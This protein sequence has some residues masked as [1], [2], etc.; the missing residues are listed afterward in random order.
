MTLMKNCSVKRRLLHS[1]PSETTVALSSSFIAVVF[2]FLSCTLP[3]CSVLSFKAGHVEAVPGSTVSRSTRP[4]PNG[5]ATAIPSSSHKNGNQF[6]PSGGGG[7]RSA[8][9]MKLT[10]PRREFGG[11]VY[12]DPNNPIA[13][14]LYAFSKSTESQ[15]IQHDDEHAPFIRFPSISSPFSNTIQSSESHL[16]Q[17]SYQR[18]PPQPSK[19]NANQHDD[20]TV[21]QGHHLQQKPLAQSVSDLLAQREEPSSIFGAPHEDDLFDSYY[22]TGI[23]DDDATLSSAD[24]DRYSSREDGDLFKKQTATPNTGTSVDASASPSLA[25]SPPPT[26]KSNAITNKIK[27]TSSNDSNSSHDNHNHSDEDNHVAVRPSST[28]A[29]RKPTLLPLPAN[30]LSLATFKQ[31]DNTL[32]KSSSNILSRIANFWR[33]RTMSSH[34]S[35]NGTIVAV[36]NRQISNSSSISSSNKTNSSTNQMNKLASDSSISADNHQHEDDDNE[37]TDNVF[38]KNLD[39]DLNR[40][41]NTRRSSSENDN[42]SYNSKDNHGKNIRRQSESSTS[43]PLTKYISM[44]DLDGGVSNGGGGGILVNSNQYLSLDDGDDGVNLGVGDEDFATST[45][46]GNTKEEGPT[47]TKSSSKNNNELEDNFHRHHDHHSVSVEDYITS[48]ETSAGL[49]WLNGGEDSAQSSHTFHDDLF[50][51]TTGTITAVIDNSSR[52]S[53]GSSSSKTHH[54][55]DLMNSG[56][57]RIERVHKSDSDKKASVVFSPSSSSGAASGGASSTSKKGDVKQAESDKIWSSIDS[58]FGRNDLIESA[59][60]E[61]EH[62]YYYGMTIGGFLK[63]ELWTIPLFVLASLNMILIILFEVYV[64]CRARGTSRRHLFLGQ[65]LLFGLFLCSFLALMFAV[66]P[67]IVGCF[68]GR[69]GVGITYS[70]IFSVLMVKCVFLL[71]LD[72]GVYLPTSYQGILLFF[73]VAVQVAIDTQWVIMYPPFLQVKRN[74]N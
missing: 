35:L 39:D 20:P 66:H 31:I 19:K 41:S 54:K 8:I 63:R 44:E 65:M 71:S 64:L 5:P 4:F 59:E 69:L 68:V 57:S 42:K 67:S 27:S 56:S 37:E 40:S 2:I 14:D 15:Q 12:E 30:Y 32:E 47:T 33:N 11:H 45:G 22:T 21:Q 58:H 23:D 73:A 13:S 1:S 7:S 36:N 55:K 62:D 18:Q 49:D 26:A 10:S 28:S 74:F 70:L 38:L 24:I 6:P 3:S 29:L 61:E 9:L 17:N 50:H 52:S 53:G 48:S 72:T 16:Q 51:T 60:S 25:N 34:S 46:G 43:L